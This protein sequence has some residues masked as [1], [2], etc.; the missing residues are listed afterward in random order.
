V[1]QLRKLARHLALSAGGLLPVRNRP[2]E[3][4]F[5][6]GHAMSVAD[7]PRFR[8]TLA[9]LRDCF[10]FVTFREA[11]AL[12]TSDERFDGRALAFS[13]DDGFRDNHDLIAPLLNEYGARA[14]FFIATN[15]IGCDELYRRDFL[16]RRV[17][18][19]EQRYPMSW[20]M[21]RT[22][23]R[24]GFEIGAHTV[25]HV[26]LAQCDTQMAIRQVQDSKQA[27]E[28]NTGAPCEW[29]AWPYGLT[30]HFPVGL[31]EAICPMFRRLFSAQRSS[32]LFGLDGAVINRDHFEPGWPTA[33]VKFFAGRPVVANRERDS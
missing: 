10:E 15:F 17:F 12:A 32:S 18:V 33:H 2:G 21:V 8:R 23:H 3:V 30:E 22:L 20:E 29:F 14:C 16:E 27:V 4:R 9:M 5:F 24:E 26:N 13:F 28:N 1:P 31:A 25:D 19:R 6:Y 7:V 11:V